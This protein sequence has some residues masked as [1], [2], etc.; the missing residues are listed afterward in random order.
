MGSTDFQKLDT[1]WDHEPPRGYALR[2]QS[3]SGDTALP[4]RVES[5]PGRRFLAERVRPTKSAVALRFPAHSK[6]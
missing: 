5:S 1:T 3:V 6:R 4:R 2:W